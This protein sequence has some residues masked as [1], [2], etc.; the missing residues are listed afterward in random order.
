MSD[1]EEMQPDQ[2]STRSSGYHVVS[3]APN[4][5]RI[6]T[7]PLTETFKILG[8]VVRFRRKTEIQAE[9]EPAEY[10][11]QILTG[12][13]RSYKLLEDGRRQIIA[14]HLPG[15]VIELEID[16]DY[17]FSA[18]AIVPSTLR[19]VKR[20]AMTRAAASNPAVAF[21]IWR[22]A[23]NVLGSANQ[24]ALLLGRK[25]AEERIAS[26]FLEMAQRSASPDIFLPMSRRD[27]AD[28]L[29]LTI[30]TVS[31]MF[32][33]FQ[34]TSTINVKNCRRVRLLNIGILRRL[35]NGYEPDCFNGSTAPG[36]TTVM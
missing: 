30:E 3:I 14:F 13:A 24:H 22:R 10:F 20:S 16:A 35:N 9:E 27:I 36:S 33:H 28:Y 18:E 6:A 31:R 4:H 19:V 25:K 5:N 23:S 26:F 1:Q 11:Y 34:R 32:S 8:T 2:A 17:K 15:D 7:D 12:A 29:G 21:E